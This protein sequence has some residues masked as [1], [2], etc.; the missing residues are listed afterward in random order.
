MSQEDPLMTA[1]SFD[2]LAATAA[3]LTPSTAALQAMSER[4]QEE[5][6]RGLGGRGGSLKVLPTFLRQPRGDERGEVLFVDWGGTRGRAGRVRLGGDGRVDMVQEDVFTFSSEDKAE[7]ADHVFDTI[8]AALERVAGRDRSSRPL[9]LAYSFPARLERIDPAIALP[10]TK[11]WQLPGLEGHDV[12]GLLARAL[13]RRGLDNVAVS[14]V[15]NDTVAAL[16]LLSFRIRSRDR[17][18]R[19]AEIGL[20]VGTGT[21]QAADLGTLGIRN[22]ESG[23]FDAVTALE[24]PCDV[25]LDREVREPRPGAQRLEK[26]VAGQYLGELVRRLVI[27]LAPRST[28]FRSW[29]G[30]AF[31]GPFGFETA[32]LSRI[33]ADGSPDLSESER[34]LRGL[35]IESSAEERRALKT[36]AR[37]VVT[38]S[39]RL[40]AAALLGTLRRIDPRLESPHRIAVDGSLYGGYP[41]YDGLVRRGLEDLAGSAPADR[42]RLEFVKDST[43]L[44]A[45]VIAA[46]ARDR[47]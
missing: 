25:A 10:L 5:I 9:G 45:A 2:P 11:G 4:F 36:L 26:M 47:E 31:Q 1:H 32:N 40:I 34:L 17:A 12:V 43:G 3:A 13:Q 7:P 35:G 28:L 15:A 44:G 41:N 8:A 30:A 14:A 18:A 21:N 16:A 19:P 39:A 37:L 27:D 38:R 33:E 46:V 23:N 24:A 42:V 6:E 29:T 20:I 22:L